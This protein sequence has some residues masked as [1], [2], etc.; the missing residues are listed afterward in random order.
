MG[1]VSQHDGHHAGLLGK[2]ATGAR[3]NAICS[4]CGQSGHRASKCPRRPSNLRQGGR[5]LGGYLDT[6]K[7]AAAR[8]R[9]YGGFLVWLLM[10][11]G[12]RP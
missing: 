3:M 9:V 11:L 5:F 4:Y 6:I 8:W 10:M 1:A 7:D 2:N 12:V